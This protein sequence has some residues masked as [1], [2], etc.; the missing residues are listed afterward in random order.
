MSSDNVEELVT[1][2]IA[3][4]NV[5]WKS[6]FTLFPYCGKQYDGSSNTRI[7]I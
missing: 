1:F 5:K 6:H 7:T 2:S 4:G 3:D